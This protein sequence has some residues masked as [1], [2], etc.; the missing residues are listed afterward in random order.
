MQLQK[1]KGQDH[2]SV[3]QSPCRKLNGEAHGAD[4]DLLNYLST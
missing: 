2:G 3:L 1:D 4:L